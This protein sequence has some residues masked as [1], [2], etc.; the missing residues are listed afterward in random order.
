MWVIEGRSVRIWV[1]SQ[2]H[3]SF[4]GDAITHECLPTTNDWGESGPH[5]EAARISKLPLHWTATIATSGELEDSLKNE[6]IVTG[7]RYRRPLSAAAAFVV[8]DD[9]VSFRF[10]LAASHFVDVYDALKVFLTTSIAKPSYII[11]HDFLG[12]RHPTSDVLLPTA[13]E[14]YQHGHPY[15]SEDPPT[16]SFLFNREAL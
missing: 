5:G 3:V 8:Y 12:T 1:S 6:M 11:T 2:G 16:R 9:M 7:G 14:F 10:N 13:E 4:G 15:V